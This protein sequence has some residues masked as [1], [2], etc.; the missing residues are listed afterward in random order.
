MPATASRALILFLAVAGLFVYRMHYKPPMIA[1]M[2]SA[3][4]SQL[5]Q[6][7]LSP[8]MRTMEKDVQRT[9]ALVTSKPD[10][11]DD[12]VRPGEADGLRR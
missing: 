1:L 4:R 2:Q 6:S 10:S 8:L 3:A 9:I 5:V 7:I 12:E 11:P